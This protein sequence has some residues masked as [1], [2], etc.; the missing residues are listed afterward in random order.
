MTELQA[1]LQREQSIGVET[2]DGSSDIL[3]HHT[4]AELL[5]RAVTSR[6]GMLVVDEYHMLSD[7]HKEELY[8][9]LQDRL[10]VLRVVL[11]A[12]RIDSR[13]RDRLNRCKAA[14]HED[15]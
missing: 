5:T 14:R 7:E 3:V 13:D 4:L 6:I 8:L 1:E 15:D 11:I 10:G 12:N 9:W 2:F